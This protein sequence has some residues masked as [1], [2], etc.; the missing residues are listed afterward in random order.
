MELTERGC[1]FALPIINELDDMESRAVA[2]FGAKR[3]DKLAGEMQAFVGELERVM[4]H[5]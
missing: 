5:D 3:A 4:S 2:T 1:A